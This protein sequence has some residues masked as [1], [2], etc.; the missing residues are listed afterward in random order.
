MVT[1]CNKKS[2]C[3]FCP[4][5]FAKGTCYGPFVK[6]G[7]F[8]SSDTAYGVGAV[9]EFA[10]DPGY[11]LEQGSVI[12]E[13]VDAENPQW[14][15]TEPACRGESSSHF[16]ARPQNF[17]CSCLANSLSASEYNLGSP[18]TIKPVSQ[19]LIVND[20]SKCNAS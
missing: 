18:V 13:C 8:T 19:D 3:D 15:E 2:T 16:K 5:A 12:I 6:Y 10:C 20:F 1:Y 11:T 17:P 14:N 9:V 7:N 4:A